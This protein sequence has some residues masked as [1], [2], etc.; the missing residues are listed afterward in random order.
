MTKAL[1]VG[2]VGTGRWAE[3]MYLPTLR[4]H[5]GVQIA[6]ICGRNRERA[7]QVARDHDIPRVFTDF[8]QIIEQG[9]LHA[10]LVTTP[11]DLH[12]PIVMRALV[13]G[14][15]VLCEKPLANTAADA[16]EMYEAAKAA[17]VTHMVLF[18]WRWQPH[19]QYLKE[20]I[21][22]GYIGRCFHAHF[23]FLAGYGR[24][25]HYMWRFDPQ[26]GNG[27][28]GDLGSHMIDFAR[29]YFG[30]VAK[31]SAHL[32]TFVER[33]GI[34]GRPQDSANDSAIVTLEFANGTHATIQVSA[35][36]HTGDRWAEQHLALHGDAGTLYLDVSFHGAESGVVIRGAQ[37][38]EDRFHTLLVPGCESG[39]LVGPSIV[40]GLFV[41]AIAEGRPAIPDFYD[42][43][44]VQEVI[45]AALQSHRTGRQVSLQHHANR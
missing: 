36:A 40:P 18:I 39:P 8:R 41:D 17:R 44:K 31:V 15:H 22:R 20:L 16:R 2:I 34:D 37:R 43:F 9:D 30:D 3:Q 27:I 26:R 23:A 12:H 6:A 29:W 42:G 14:L 4:S 5:P 32:A 19:F 38:N 45:D 10:V 7:E 35:V 24:G 33:P 25:G 13:N 21:D 11:D 28:L 1:R